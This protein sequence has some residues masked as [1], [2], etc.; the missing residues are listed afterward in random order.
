MDFRDSPA[1]AEFRSRL[2]AWL[3]EHNPGLPASSTED[4]YWTRQAE[5]HIALYDAG[6][7]GLSWP[8]RYGGHELP[9]VFD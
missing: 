3:T 2:R 7:F 8:A 5:W 4:A 6:F 1:E 9:T